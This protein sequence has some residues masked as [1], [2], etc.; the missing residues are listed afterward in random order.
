MVVDSDVLE[1]KMRRVNSLRR[2]GCGQLVGD[3]GAAWESLEGGSDIGFT[4]D[5]EVPVDD[6][7]RVRIVDLYLPERHVVDVDECIATR[8][9]DAVRVLL[10][11]QPAQIPCDR[12]DARL[13]RTLVEVDVDP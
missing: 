1:P 3:G 9:A 4:D 8:P 11:Q 7:W 5:A 6:R 12:F 2:S 10:Q 13:A